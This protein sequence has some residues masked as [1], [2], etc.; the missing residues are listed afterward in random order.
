P[1]QYQEHATARAGLIT[2]A[3]YEL[4]RDGLRWRYSGAAGAAE[5]STL[6]FRPLGYVG[7]DAFVEAI[8]ATYEGTRDSWRTTNIEEEGLL[9]AARSDL[10]DPKRPDDRPEWWGVGRADAS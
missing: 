10:E 8:A 4:L 2:E 7:E 5:A 1:P 3:G 9:G 6:T